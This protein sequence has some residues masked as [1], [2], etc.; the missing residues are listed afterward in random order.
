VEEELTAALCFSLDAL[1][2]EMCERDVPARLSASAVLADC[3]ISAMCDDRSFFPEFFLM[4]GG[5]PPAAAPADGP[6]DM[7]LDIHACAHPAFGWFR[8]SGTNGLPVDG[9]EFTFALE[10][11]RSVFRALPVEEPG[12]NCLGFRDTDALALAFRG[13]DCVFALDPQ[14]R[15]TI[16]WYLFWRLLRM[17]SD[18]IFFHA[19]SI[20]VAGNGVMF[21]GPAGGGKTTTALALAS[22]GHDFLGDEIAAYIPE[23]GNLVPFRR[24][25]GVKPGPKPAAVERALASGRLQRVARDQAVGR[26][27]VRVDVEELLRVDPPR[28]VPLRRVVFLRGFAERPSLERIH[29]GRAEIVELQPLMSSFLNAP[30]TRRVFELTRLLA[31]A[32]VYALRPGAPDD[33]AAYLE[34]QFACEQ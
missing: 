4:F 24:P 10:A 14:W 28:A 19:S 22:R 6:A 33:T 34:K 7:H 21:V 23:N 27:F 20:G 30:H 2:A 26:D 31:A 15:R 13:N 25:V 17:R 9:R 18:A 3:R 12:W 32:K 29:P 8:M 5:K 16:M 11:K 1:L